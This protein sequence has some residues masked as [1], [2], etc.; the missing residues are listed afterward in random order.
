[1]D[2]AGACR[3]HAVREIMRH[4]AGGE[5]YKTGTH[6]HDRDDVVGRQG[7]PPPIRGS[8]HPE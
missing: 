4:G 8:K 5:G 1:M 6:C 7:S 3:L 2:V